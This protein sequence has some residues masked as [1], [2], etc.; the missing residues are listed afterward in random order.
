VLCTTIISTCI[1]SPM[2][3]P[4]TSIAIEAPRKLVPASSRDSR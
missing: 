3:A 2:P 4:S 1:I